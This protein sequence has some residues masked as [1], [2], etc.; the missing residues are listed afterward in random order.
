MFEPVARTISCSFLST[1]AVIRAFIF[2]TLCMY[3]N[4]RQN[5]SIGKEDFNVTRVKDL[6]GGAIQYCNASAENGF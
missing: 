5:S 2:L 4:V 6:G 1:E 3:H